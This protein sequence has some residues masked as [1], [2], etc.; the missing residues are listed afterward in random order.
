M[1]VVRIVLI[2]SRPAEDEEKAQMVFYN[3]RREDSLGYFYMSDT[4]VIT[5]EGK[6]NPLQYSCLE[7]P[8][9]RGA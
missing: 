5:G 2:Q 6:G 7:N 9:V 3:F 1:P 8:M 4:F